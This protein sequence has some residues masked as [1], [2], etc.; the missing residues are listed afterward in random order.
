MH[1]FEKGE[2]PPPLKPKIYDLR[3]FKFLERNCNTMK[4]TLYK[5]LDDEGKKTFNKYICWSISNICQ[6]NA[7]QPVANFMLQGVLYLSHLIFLKIMCEGHEIILPSWS[8]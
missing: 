8:W 1:V 5:Y 4:Q 7:M 3:Y 2:A 6:T